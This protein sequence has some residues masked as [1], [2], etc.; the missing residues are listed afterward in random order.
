[1]YFFRI[2]FILGVFLV[3]AAT[4]C[5]N[6]GSQVPESK[7]YISQERLS[8]KDSILDAS[9][10]LAMGA[11]DREGNF[12]K[13]ASALNEQM[14]LYR[15]REL[16][17]ML[18]VAYYN[19]YAAYKR[20]GKKAAAS[21]YRDSILWLVTAKNKP[22]LRPV[23]NLS[24]GFDDMIRATDSSLHYLALALNDSIYLN[25]NR[26]QAILGG[27]AQNY[28]DKKYFTLSKEYA[29]RALDISPYIPSV[30][31]MVADRKVLYLSMIAAS[32]F[33]LKDTL[34]AAPYLKE[35]LNINR[36]LGN[37]AQLYPY[38]L[39]GDFFLE[40]KDYDSAFYYFNHHKK[41]AAIRYSNLFSSYVNIGKAQL[42]L[43]NTQQSAKW[44]DSAMVSFKEWS[45][46]NNSPEDYLA[47][48]KLLYEHRMKEGN[49]ASALYAL[50]Q[51]YD[52]RNKQFAEEKSDYMKQL[53][54][55]LTKARSEKAIEEKEQKI[56][57]QRLYT[58]LAVITSL[59]I[60]VIGYLLFN[61]QRRKKLLAAQRLR[62]MEQQ[63]YIEKVQHRIQAE[64]EERNRIAQEI[65]D[66]IGASLTS[67]N[68][69]AGIIAKPGSNPEYA[70]GIIVKHT[71]LLNRQINEIIWS[72]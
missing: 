11:A 9:L 16:F 64:S 1:M 65:H 55:S 28:F 13:Y 40:K 20:Q 35:A 45:K 69:A 21:L 24:M 63:L 14:N 34:N 57:Q 3:F 54:E 31:N 41:I 72:A 23:Y 18:G 67:L 70:A 43:G 48:Y 37:A 7:F 46:R 58:L 5:K 49:L 4:A 30:A 33:H 38:Q 2:G 15:S 32:L 61:N 22:E 19:A 71:K 6:T 66:D 51:L 44:L 39:A 60:A 17:E 10:D 26:K 29:Q 68:M 27:I 25:A 47:Y 8:P 53:E 59:V 42:Q 56:K 50:Q 62:A 52:V 36:D 12:E